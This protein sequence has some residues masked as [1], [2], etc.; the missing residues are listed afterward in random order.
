VP[1]LGFRSFIWFGC[2]FAEALDR[3]HG[4]GAAYLNPPTH[5]TYRYFIYLCSPYATYQSPAKHG[6]IA[7]QTSRPGGAGPQRVLAQSQGQARWQVVGT[8]TES[9]KAGKAFRATTD[10]ND[11]SGT[12]RCV[13]DP[14][15]GR[16]V[17]ETDLAVVAGNGVA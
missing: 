16:R 14:G 3:R 12:R 11:G 17:E 4:T 7:C 9:G 1:D 2:L 15:A 6:C 5:G 8:G 13:K 10:G